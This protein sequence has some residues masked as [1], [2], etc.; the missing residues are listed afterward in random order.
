[1]KEA[2]AGSRLGLMLAATLALVGFLVWSWPL[3]Q[4]LS[5][6]TLELGAAAQGDPGWK[7]ITANDQNLS[8]WSAVWNARA[9]LRGDFAGVLSQGQCYPQPSATALGEHLIELGVVLAPWLLLAGDPVVSFNLSI[10]TTLVIAATGM[11]LFLYRHTGSVPAS[12]AGAVVFAFTTPRLADV[13]AHPAVVGTHWIP[14]VLWSFDGALSGEGARSLILFALTLVLST[15]VGSYPLLQIGIV[16]GA[17]GAAAIALRLRRG[18]LDHAALARVVVAAAPAFAIVAA[19]LLVYANVQN[20]WGVAG[21]PDAKFLVGFADYLPGGLLPVGLPALLGL[22]LLFVRRDSSSAAVWCLVAASVPAV[23][24]ATRLP[25][26][27]GST[28][29]AYEALASRFALLD[30][31]R[32]PGK[33]AMAV[34]FCVQALGMIG[35]S[36]LMHLAG[37]PAAVVMAAFVIALA[38]AEV[39]PP[40]IAGGALG[41]GVPMELR[42]LAPPLARTEVLSS[43]LGDPRDGRAVLDLPP[44]MMVRSPAALLDAVWHGRPTSACYNT[45]ETAVVRETRVLA[46]R[47]HSARG[48]AE[49]SAAGFGFVIERP[50]KPAAKLSPTSFPPPARLLNLG[51]GMAIWELPPSPPAHHD[52]ARLSF[53]AVGGA[54]RR[55]E[56]TGAPVHEI[57][58]E[59]ANRDERM[60]VAPRPVAP[61]LARVVVSSEGGESPAIARGVL[62]LAL[63]PGT[64]TLAKLVTDEALAPGSRLSQVRIDGVDSVAVAP[65]FRWRD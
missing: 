6:H 50:A 26:P 54:T 38:A 30:S 14:W 22:P 43:V 60:W 45:F 36:R 40:R 61:L 1:V 12:V 20:E 27:D 53:V 21:H 63:S 18:D 7:T 56:R 51:E 46:D 8:F 16:G 49:L 11:F 19:V 35:W 59:I 41:A 64:T 25:L 24:V 57:D 5:T 13:A 47:S 9:I 31:V 58:V 44:G 48:V 17:Y 55:D 2:R 28:W 33:C 39:S 42:E 23:L 3:A 52:L 4:H 32:A 29:S 37:K 34:G 15:L 65:A 62:P 10:A